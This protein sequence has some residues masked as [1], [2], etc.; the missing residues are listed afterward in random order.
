MSIKDKP[1]NQRLSMHN[2]YKRRL[3]GLS[4][5]LA[6]FL[7]YA[8]M[9]LDESISGNIYKRE[10]IERITEK[11]RELAELLPTP[12]D[13]LDCPSIRE[14]F[15][16]ILQQTPDNTD[17]IIANA[18]AFFQGLSREEWDEMIKTYNQKS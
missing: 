14:D 4:L 2:K 16:E 18:E 3:K 5:I 17:K 7:H 1:K 10:E 6:D 9:K 15:L 11:V 13:T 8:E 12:E